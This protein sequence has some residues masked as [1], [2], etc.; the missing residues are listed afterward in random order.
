MLSRRRK[1][2]DPNS[3]PKPRRKA[4]VR[5]RRMTVFIHV[6]EALICFAVLGGIGYAFTEYVTASPRFKVSSLQIEGIQALSPLAL[7][8][9]T[10]SVSKPY[11]R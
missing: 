10:T 6:A 11:S 4:L 5:R 2:A 3:N 8:S 7:T 1:A 9:V